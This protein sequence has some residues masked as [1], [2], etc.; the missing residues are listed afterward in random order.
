MFESL[1]GQL[2]GV[3]KNILIDADYL[4]FALGPDGRPVSAPLSAQ[5][6]FAVPTSVASELGCVFAN[7]SANLL[8]A[9]ASSNRLSTPSAR[10]GIKS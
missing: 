10:I 2:N 4:V 8:V 1:E 7:L 3:I 9:T 6:L 5:N